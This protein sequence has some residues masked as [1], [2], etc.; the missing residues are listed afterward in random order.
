MVRVMTKSYNFMSKDCGA[1]LYNK[2]LKC[3]QIGIL[4]K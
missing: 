2:L 1:M 3:Q 4:A